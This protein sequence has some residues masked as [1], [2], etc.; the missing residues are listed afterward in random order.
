MPGE[1][2]A[3]KWVHRAVITRDGAGR[4]VVPELR[5]AQHYGRA[6]LA[7]AERKLNGRPRKT[8]DWRKPR[9]RRT[10]LIALTG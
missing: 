6:N 2:V 9:E 1:D 10:E 8:L 3:A 5:G 4:E 7:E